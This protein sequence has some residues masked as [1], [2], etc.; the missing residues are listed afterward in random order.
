[1]RILLQNSL[2]Y[3][4]LV[5]GA[6][7]STLLLAR[8]LSARGH[9]VDVLATSGRPGDAAAFAEAAVDGVSGRA[10][11]APAA[12]SLPL[13][14]GAGA[15]P[16]LLRKA[17]H[18]AQ[19]VHDR[20]W[21]RRTAA[22]LADRRPDVLHTNNLVGV[23]TAAWVAAARARVPVVHTLRDLHLLCPRT[24]L[25]R[26]DGTV[27]QRRPLPCVALSKAKLRHSHRVDVV[28]S[29]TRFNLDLHLEAG[30]FRR[31]RREVVPNACETLPADLPD[32]RDRARVRVL[33]L[34]ALA[35]YKGVPELLA[36]FERLAADPAL[37]HVDLVL[38][39]AGEL[40]TTVRQAA[41]R[42]AGRVAYLGVV[43]D[44]AKDRALREADVLVAPSTCLETYGRVLLDAFSYGLP[45]VGSD[46]GGIPEVIRDGEDGLVVPPT[47]DALAAALAF[48]ASD[49]ER[50]LAMGAAA[51]ARAGALDVTAQARAFEAIY[52]DLAG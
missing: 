25:L 26:S 17:W 43:R 31:A 12:G 34:G 7:H 1:M 40:E 41:S 11:T 36:A 9:L 29:P 32:R 18:H 48:L 13:L 24:T 10:Y 14:P 16:N 30:G 38:A 46:R 8:E 44:E 3:P 19:N 39:G 33:F 42:S 47:P 2:F 4:D 5:G 23:T 22:L 45:V 50:R 15:A 21:R 51:R 49:A 27:C 35:P 28:T 6:E 37:A 20:T 52:G